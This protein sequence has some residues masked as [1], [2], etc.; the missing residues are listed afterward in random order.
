MASPPQKESHPHSNLQHPHPPVPFVTALLM[1]TPNALMWRMAYTGS[2]VRIIN[3]AIKSPLGPSA[4]LLLPFLGMAMEKS[5]YDSAMSLQ[6]IDPNDTPEYH[7]KDEQG[8]S[9][10]SFPGGGHNLPSLSYFPVR[11]YSEYWKWFAAPPKS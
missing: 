10:Q 5:F 9:T 8:R 4:L 11:H 6:G 2:G 7:Q 3:V 1:L